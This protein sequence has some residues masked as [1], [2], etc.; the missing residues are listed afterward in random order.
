MNYL[1][2]K[3]FNY[4]Y[5]VFHFL[6]VTYSK[7]HVKYKSK[8]VGKNLVIKGFCSGFNKNVDI[9]DNVSFN[10]CHILGAGNVKFGSFFHSGKN[11]T[12][13]TEN[14]RYDGS[15]K[16]PYDKKRIKKQTVIGDFVWIGHGC[17]LNPG[18]KIDE[19]AIIAAR[20]HVV[21]NVEKYQIVGGNPARFIKYRDKKSFLLNKKNKNFF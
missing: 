13:L 9:A 5:K 17:T 2:L 6:I 7:V 21:K 1:F 12:I 8:T 18:V 14:H 19:G 4:I 20:S 16:I 10:G 15:E 3:L 11:L